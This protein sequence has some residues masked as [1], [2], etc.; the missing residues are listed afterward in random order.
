MFL[1]VNKDTGGDAFVLTFPICNIT[2]S[3]TKFTNL[4]I[5]VLILLTKFNVV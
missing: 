2:F 5:L 3:F 4:L 1:T